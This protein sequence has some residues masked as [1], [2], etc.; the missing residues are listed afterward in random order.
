MV[1]LW[2]YRHDSHT[3]SDAMH[4]DLGGP[5]VHKFHVALHQTHVVALP[6]TKLNPE[7]VLVCVTMRHL[8]LLHCIC[9]LSLLQVL[10]SHPVR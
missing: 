4:G 8:L 3:Y 1:L 10:L 9:N 5:S 6:P 7:A 2:L